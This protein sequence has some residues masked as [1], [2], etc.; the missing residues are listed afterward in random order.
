MFTLNNSI[1]LL[2]LQPHWLPTFVMKKRGIKMYVIK[3]PS[4]IALSTAL[5]IAG[6]CATTE[7]DT[8]AVSSS[9]AQDEYRAMLQDKEAEIQRLRTSL[10]EGQSSSAAASSS[11]DGDLFP[12]NAQPG[13]CYARVLIPA[14]YVTESETV[15]KREASYRYDIVAPVYEWSTEQVLVKEESSR[16]EVIPATYTQVTEQLLVKPESTRLI[17]VPAEYETVSETVLDKAAHT[18]WKR[19]SGPVDGALQ[20]A[21]DQSTGEVVCLVEVPASYRTV[22]KTVL[23]SPARTDEIVVPGE[24]NTVTRRVV[25]TPA[26]TRTVVIPAEYKTVKSQ[27]LVTP[28]QKTKIDIPAE[29]ETVTNRKKVSEESLSWREVLCQDNLTAGV[30]TD[31]QESLSDAGFNR[32]GADGRL[33]PV[34]LRNVNAYAKSKGLP[35]GKN[36]IAIETAKALGVL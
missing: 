11:R 32:T 3:L 36:Y 26:S 13:H 28:A 31:I 18:V 35:Q 22:S 29:Y 10:Q 24:Y 19:G 1:V 25:D 33:G 6:G 30:I 8:A 4:V 20:T 14:D 2:P 15:M 21:Y 27:K 12:P 7:N 23:R 9:A 5:L 17:E 34:T 16:L